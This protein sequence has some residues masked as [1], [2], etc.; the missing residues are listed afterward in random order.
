MAIQV[1]PVPAGVR[2][3]TGDH[4]SHV[5]LAR[6]ERQ[7]REACNVAAVAAR[8]V[9]R[10]P[11]PPARIAP[12]PKVFV[13]GCP[14]SG[15]S[16]VQTI[17]AQHPAVV[18]SQESHAYEQVYDPV[19]ARGARNIAA[20]A[21]V[22]HRHDISERQQRWVGLHW[23]VNRAR[24]LDLVAWAVHQHDA[25][26]VVAQRVIEAIF[27]AGFVE[28]GGDPSRTLLEK[29]PG[30]LHYARQILRRFPEARVVEV[31]RDGRDVCVSLEKLR[32]TVAW[33]PATRRAQVELWARAAKRGL[34]LRRD[35]EFADRVHLVRYETLKADPT[36]EIARLYSFAD[37]PAD[38]AFVAG[39]ADA[40]DFRHHRSTGEGRHTRRGEVG[41]WEQHLDARDRALFRELAGDV[42][43]AAGYRFDDAQ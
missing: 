17:L 25:P 6:G 18:T 26:D 7:W 43:E 13:V 33:P 23:W 4:F 3:I 16:W 38:D 8:R 29:S 21:K 5:D 19:V 31:L 9:R 41:D 10:A 12:Y 24:L 28:R 30:H 32:A 2:P 36:A 20:W 27:D 14:R 39:V 37:L 1:P 15:T 40:T 42:F 11:D 22:L 34:E 35:P